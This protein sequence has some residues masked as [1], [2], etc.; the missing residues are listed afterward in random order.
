MFRFFICVEYLFS[1]HLG[2]PA[3]ALGDCNDLTAYEQDD[4][5]VAGAAHGS[6]RPVLSAVSVAVLLDEGDRV[7]VLLETFH[8]WEGRGGCPSAGGVGRRRKD[9]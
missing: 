8:A 3:V 6:C 9:R 5:D 2:L 7:A 4:G 1:P